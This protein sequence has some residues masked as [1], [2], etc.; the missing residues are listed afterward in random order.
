MAFK[1]DLIILKNQVHTSNDI[2]NLSLDMFI[3]YD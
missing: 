3:N 1:K 2:I